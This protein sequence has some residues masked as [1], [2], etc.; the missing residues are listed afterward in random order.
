M[1]EEKLETETAR[2]D[3]PSRQIRVHNIK[4][5]YFRVVHADGVWGGVTAHG[6]VQMAFWSERT[7][8]PKELTYTFEPGSKELK[9]SPED[10][11]GREGWVRE[12]EV[13]VL[14]DLP[15]AISFR[16]WLDEKIKTLGRELGPIEKLE[17]IGD[18]RDSEG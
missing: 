10:R 17:A 18:L 2:A 9:E 14:M 12:M 3:A 6:F 15:T 4:S 11:T 13:S 7:A 8:I 1:S 5:N 16:G